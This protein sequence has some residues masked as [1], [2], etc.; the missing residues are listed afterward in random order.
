MLI[1]YY[2]LSFFDTVSM[3]AL[4]H[5]LQQI[6]CLQLTAEATEFMHSQ[7]S[8]PP[9]EGLLTVFAGEFDHIVP[10]D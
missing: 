10:L 3:P 6:S 9:G 2:S 7:N 1:S 5:R 4:L 8:L